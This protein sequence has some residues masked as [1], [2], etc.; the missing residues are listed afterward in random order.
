MKLDKLDWIDALDETRTELRAAW[1]Y[2]EKVKLLYAAIEKK[3]EFLK[4]E[5]KPFGVNDD[6]DY[7]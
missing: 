4:A 5:D 3:V 1:M 6:E 2:Y 7:D